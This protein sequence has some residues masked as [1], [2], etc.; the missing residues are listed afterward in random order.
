MS[1]PAYSVDFTQATSPVLS[2]MKAYDNAETNQQ[3]RANMQQQAAYMKEET[4]GAENKNAMG[5]IQL[6]EAQ[7]QEEKL[8]RRVPLDSLKEFKE[9]FPNTAGGMYQMAKDLNMVESVGG[10]E[11]ISVRDMQELG[12]YG[13]M[14]HEMSQK[15]YEW[16]SKDLSIQESA[17]IQKGAEAKKPED[18]QAIGEQLTKLRKTQSD[19]YN[20]QFKRDMTV[21]E[22]AKDY[23]PASIAKWNKSGD[24][25]DLVPMKI[26][27]A[28]TK[29]DARLTEE[30]QKQDAA[31]VLQEQKD[32]AAGGRADSTN[33]SREK[34]QAMRDASGAGGN[35]GGGGGSAAPVTLNE[36]GK[37]EDAIK[38][39]SA[40][41]QS[42]VK[43]IA[44]Y[45]FPVSNLRNKNMMAL[46]KKAYEYNP[47]FDTKEYAVKA[48]VRK[49]FT[50]GKT[51]NN[52]N[53]LNTAVGHLEQMFDKAQALKNTDIPA[54][55]WIAN[56]GL[57]ATGD[58]R[59]AGFN[60]TAIAVESELASVFKGMGAT[61]QEIK[62]W[63]D[64]FSSSSSPAQF[65][66]SIVDSS[67]KLMGS[68][69]DALR[70][71]YEQGMGE[72]AN[73]KLLSKRSH[74]ILKKMGADTNM[75]DPGESE[76]GRGGTKLPEGLKAGW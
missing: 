22:M 24:M 25:E 54:W 50:S 7:R 30:K 62:A 49:D 52:I 61:D 75:I 69:L 33:K 29:A 14:T 37:N 8:D 38:G 18:K 17:L 55:N 3:Q 2:G 12:K 13:D 26:A 66:E 56:K 63:R 74:D 44:E 48:A 45:R 35:L 73:F 60:Q 59:I 53:S 20:M 40:Q 34:V 65:K 10:K 4:K 9:K 36:K 39:L 76:A 51:A 28:G 42:T 71:K 21:K 67:T 16:M 31:K 43:A 23:T 68:R 32:K 15:H 27:E 19:L 5:A 11:S 58:K 47:T 6:K 1:N 46:V 70:N 41:D 72:P 64:G 57:Q